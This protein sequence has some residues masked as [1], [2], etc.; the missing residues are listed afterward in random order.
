MDDKKKTQDYSKVVNKVKDLYK[1]SNNAKEPFISTW[2]ECISA[3]NGDKKEYVPSYKSDNSTNMIFSTLET[4]RPIMLSE[5][6]KFQVFPRLEK[7]Y[8]K[9]QRVEQGLNYEWDR[10]KMYSILPKLLLTALQTGT[11]IIGLFYDGKEIQPTLIS[12]FNFFI[13]PSATTLDEAEYCIYASYVNVGQ[14]IK[15]Y[16]NAREELIKQKQTPNEENLVFGRDTGTLNNNQVLV[17]ETYIKDYSME[18]F[19]EEENGEKVTKSKMK[20]PNLRRIIVGGDVLLE[21]KPNPYEDN[22]KFPFVVLKDYDLPNQFWGVGDV[23]HIMKPQKYMDSLLNTVLDNAKN[24]GNG[25]WVIDKNSGIDTSTLTNRPGLILKKNPNSEVARLTPPQLPSYLLNTYQTIMENI[26]K[27][28]GVNETTRGFRPNSITSGSALQTLTENSQGRIR[29]KMVYLESMLGELGSMWVRRIKQF[30]DLPRQIRIMVSANSLQQTLSTMQQ[31]GQPYSVKQPYGDMYP[32]FTSVDGDSI[33]GE[34]DISVVGGSTLPVNKGQKLNY[35]I[36]LANLRGE[37]NLPLVDRQTIL[38]NSEVSNVQEILQRFESIKQANAQQQTQG[39][40]NMQQEQFANQSYASQ[41]EMQK[42][43]QK[44]DLELQKLQLEHNNKAQEQ[45]KDRAI[46]LLQTQMQGANAEKQTQSNSDNIIN[47]EN[48]EEMLPCG[49]SV[50][51]VESVIAYLQT[52]QEQE[53]VQIMQ[54]PQ[55]AQMLQEYQDFMQTKGGL[56]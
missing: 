18:N 38:E 50:K 46:S 1:K 37:D 52:L 44:H 20:Y 22:G 10:T 16:P 14:L 28:T 25:M 4:I 33:D 31:N 23:Q 35:L 29:L 21:D 54:N 15:K 43:K 30:W 32:V 7:D 48:G 55:I 5:T 19:E 41:L 12:P 45:D 3:Y 8:D 9:C 39:Q 51:D 2:K 27:I 53:R 49:Y 17:L 13:D 34:W 24:M 42:A 11:G 6:P 56:S 47:G 36:Q 40:A 26:E